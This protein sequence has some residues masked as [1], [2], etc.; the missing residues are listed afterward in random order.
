MHPR[1]SFPRPSRSVVG[2]FASLSRGGLTLNIRGFPRERPLSPLTIS[3]SDMP[4]REEILE[5]LRSCAVEEC[6]WRATQGLYCSLCANKRLQVPPSPRPSTTVGGIEALSP[7]LGG[8]QVT[9]GEVYL[10]PGPPPTRSTTPL[11]PQPR[12]CPILSADDHIA[13]LE[14]QQESVGG[15]R[16]TANSSTTRGPR[17]SS[18]APR[19]VALTTTVVTNIGVLNTP[20][21]PSPP[22]FASGPLRTPPSAPL[23]PRATTVAKRVER[24]PASQSLVLPPSRR[25]RVT[26]GH[27]RPGES[28]TSVQLPDATDELILHP[29]SE[30]AR[31][32]DLGSQALAA[33]QTL[34]PVNPD[35][36]ISAAKTA[37]FTASGHCFEESRDHAREF[38]RQSHLIQAGRDILLMTWP[39]I[40]RLLQAGMES[41]AVGHDVANVIDEAASKLTGNFNCQLNLYLQPFAL[42]N[43][44]VPVGDGRWIKQRVVRRATQLCLKSRRRRLDELG[45]RLRYTTVA[46]LPIIALCPPLR[47]LRDLAMIG[48]V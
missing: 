40:E 6:G 36:L 24:S 39:L 15:L 31:A 17:N 10:V 11:P 21:T 41:S 9:S 3:L 14:T 23:V 1:T 33:P 30:E 43:T 28:S 7:L 20:P 37:L 48:T 27:R 29:L 12:A 22:R 38:L 34:Q 4:T 46:P 47:A 32:L 16:I 2:S 26:V 8:L 13:L 44:A 42:T 19:T 5:I 18:A 25:R 45:E 35:L